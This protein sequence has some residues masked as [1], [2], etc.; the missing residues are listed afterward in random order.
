LLA[1]LRAL[2]TKGS[3]YADRLRRANLYHEAPAGADLERHLR[4]AVD[5]LTRAQ[6]AGTNRGVSYGVD[7]GGAWLESYPETTGYII[8]TFLKVADAYHDES[9]L[10]RAV[11]MGRWESDVQMES[12]AV[13]GGRYNTNPTPAVFNTGMVLLGWSALYERTAEPRFLASLRR[14]S[15]WL[16]SLQEPDGDWRKGNSQFANPDIT[17]YNVKAA[18]GLAEAGRV[19]AIAGA[20]DGAVRNAEFCLSRQLPN[21]W[22]RDCCLVDASQPLLHTIAYA[23]QG[24]IGIGGIAKRQEFVQAARRTADSLIRLMDEDGFIPGCIGPDFRGTVDWCCLTGTAQTAI[25]WG[26]LFQLTGEARYREA[27]QRA[28]RYLMQRHDID[29]SDPRLR[30]GVPGSWPVWGEYGRLRILNWATNFFVEALVLQ[31]SIA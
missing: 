30:G 27:M 24:L 31:R 18:W 11:E 15:E 9:L 20:V 14:A 7:F 4:E 26:R 17:V 25:V 28:T 21:G 13:M 10:A 22:F 12:G 6:D 2:K 16:L 8:P 23:M 1:L 19:G 3:L 5:W 29:N